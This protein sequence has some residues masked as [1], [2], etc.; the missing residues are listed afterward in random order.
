MRQALLACAGPLAVAPPPDRSTRAI[1]VTEAEPIEEPPGPA[2]AVRRR[3]AMV[4]GGLALVVAATLGLVLRGGGAGPW[5]APP[6]TEAVPLATAPARPTPVAPTSPAPAT[7]SPAP[8]PQATPAAGR[9]AAPGPR[10]GG[11]AQAL[12]LVRR[13][14]A[15]RTE[16]DLD[17]AIR[18]YLA[19]EAADG[20]LPAVQKKLALCY[21][22]QGDTRRAREHYRR[23]LAGDPPDAAKV[24]LILETL[25]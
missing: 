12:E 9:P 17:G 18:A 10:P 25:R 15:R 11:R 22:Q 19:A 14:D 21:Q 4:A 16:G 23:Y 6:V 7:P 3:V 13:G 1:D 2:P 5:V 24:R 8:S 20:A